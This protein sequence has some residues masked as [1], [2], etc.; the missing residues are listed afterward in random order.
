[1][2]LLP[3]RALGA[4]RRARP[5]CRRPCTTRR[6]AAPRTCRPTAA[7]RAVGGFRRATRG[8]RRRIF[9]RR[10]EQTTDD[11]SSS[12]SVHPNPPR[13][14]PRRSDGR[15]RNGA[16]MKGKRSGTGRESE[17]GGGLDRRATRGAGSRSAL[18]SDA[19]PR[20]PT[21][22]GSARVRRGGSACVVAAPNCDEGRRRRDQSEC[23]RDDGS[24]RARARV[25]TDG[26]DDTTHSASDAPRHAT[27]HAAAASP[28]AA[29]C[30]R[31]T[32]G[33]WSGD[34][35]GCE[36]GV[37]FKL[38]PSMSDR[39][40]VKAKPASSA[41]RRRRRRRRRRCAAHA[42]FSRLEPERQRD[43]ARGRPAERALRGEVAGHDLATTL[44]V[45][46]RRRR[47]STALYIS[48]ARNRRIR[49]ATAPETTRNVSVTA[50]EE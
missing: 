22:D 11:P 19:E 6:A 3:V 23:A 7:A 44:R 1:M 37:S 20:A 41:R 36:Y 26:T 31:S 30:A 12:V 16:G 18:P 33:E 38:C 29:S 42:R 17:G 35:L 32:S 2:C 10:A 5:R 49:V 24:H 46:T 9:A 8:T 47:A 15:G 21:R 43:P 27:F 45:R 13:A 39:T 25:V 14:A 28:A 40:G 48:T 34:L 4:R 50:P